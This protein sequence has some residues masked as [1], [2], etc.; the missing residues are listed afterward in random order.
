[1]NTKMVFSTTGRILRLEA[2][3]LVLPLVTALLYGE[4]GGAFSFG[5]TILLCVLSGTILRLVFRP[6]DDRIYAAEGFATVALAWVGMSAFGALPFV[7]SGEIPHFADAFF[8]TVSGFTT[9]GAS[10]LTDVEAMSHGMLLWRSFTHWVGGMGV[11]VFVMALV[12][13]ISDRSIHIMRA[14]VPGPIVGKLVPRIKDSAKILYLIYVALTALEAILL[15]ACGMSVFDSI[16]H[17]FATAGTGGF[18][19]KADSVGSYAP[20]IQWILG[21]FMLLFGVNFNL[22]YLIL[23]KKAKT[24]FKSSELWCYLAI[25]FL[26]SALITVNI[27]SYYPNFSDTIRHAFFQ[28]S[29]IITTTGFSTVNFDLW[30]DLSKALLAVLM[31]C[32]GCAGS[33]AG[34][35]KVS[36]VMILFK[37][38]GREFKQMLHPRAV[39]VVRLEGKALDD[40]TISGAVH[41]LVLYVVCLFG[42]FLALSVEPFGFET[43]FTAVLSCFNNIGPG[44]AKVGPMESFAL[45]SHY[46]KYLL[47]FAMLLGRLEI[48]PLLLAVIPS[49]WHRP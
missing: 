22:Y 16:V 37:S 40:K 6:K 14:E 29:S 48:Y 47:S 32:G 33:T 21:I 46:G 11:L 44:L 5:I 17:A 30:P 28:V 13:N 36:R 19:I 18:G 27:H 31:L 39:R 45:Y 25:I 20:H 8:E 42:I 34:G 24:A 38:I 9:T 1:M 43:N 15:F 4:Y 3:L 2:I 26:S 41:Y 35:L 23:I 10:V 49:T 12:P 7:F